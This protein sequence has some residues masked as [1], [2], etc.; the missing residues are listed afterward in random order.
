MNLKNK[1]ELDLLDIVL[2]FYQNKKIIFMFVILSF[3]IF[4]LY[5]FVLHKQSYQSKIEII[6]NNDLF[7]FKESPFITSET[8]YIDRYLSEFYDYD[9]YNEWSKKI[10]KINFSKSDFGSINDNEIFYRTTRDSRM[11]NF[12]YVDK[13][14]ILFLNL[15]SNERK[16]IS[17]IFDYAEFINTKISKDLYNSLENILIN[18]EKEINNSNIIGTI[19]VIQLI[20]KNVEINNIFDISNPS[21][22]KYV[23]QSLKKYLILFIIVSLFLSFIF[24]LSKY[25]YNLKFKKNKYK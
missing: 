14:N 1:K 23:G 12:S 15:Y 3:F 16:K 7:L 22:P 9:N 11:Y 6:S 24:I 2:L 19:A 20:M 18:Y 4:L 13:D 5:Y 10:D 17:Q 8:V 21:L 25:F